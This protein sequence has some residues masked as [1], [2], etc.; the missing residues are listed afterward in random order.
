MKR[1]FALFIVMSLIFSLCSCDLLCGCE[2]DIDFPEENFDIPEK[3]SLVKY[4]LSNGDVITMLFVGSDYSPRAA[5]FYGEWKRGDKVLRI[6]TTEDP[7][8]DTCLTHGRNVYGFVM[9]IHEIT[10]LCVSD[11]YEPGIVSYLYPEEFTTLA[12][13]DAGILNSTKL[14]LD[15]GGE[16]LEIVSVSVEDSPFTYWD[17]TDPTWAEFDTYGENTHF[18]ANDINLSYHPWR[19]MGEMKIGEKAHP[20]KLVFHEEA[21][22][23]SVYDMSDNGSEFIM[24]L[25]GHMGAENADR[26]IIDDII[27]ARDFDAADNYSGIS[28]IE[29][30]K[31]EISKK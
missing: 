26:F 5:R 27:C 1:I 11:V 18:I 8:I 31:T 21:M 22:T 15:E 4:D 20:I 14:T 28:G 19:N 7:L 29:L 13:F 9:S 30:V 10:G 25:I 16:E 3:N 17:W 23:I 12:T 6:A 24:Y 2:K